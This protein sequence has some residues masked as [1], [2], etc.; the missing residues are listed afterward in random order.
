MDDEDFNLDEDSNEDYHDRINSEI[1]DI[2]KKSID[3]K[4][5][6]KIDQTKK[7][8]AFES[9]FDER[10]VFQLNKLL[11]NGPLEKIEGII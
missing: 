5:I 6:K 4:R 9:V 1:D 11:V 7:K 10:T 2:E 8:A 3:Y